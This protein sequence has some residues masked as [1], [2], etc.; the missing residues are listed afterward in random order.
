MGFLTIIFNTC[1]GKTSRENINK[2]I[3]YFRRL[4]LPNRPSVPNLSYQPSQPK[5]A[6]PNGGNT[7]GKYSDILF[8]AGKSSSAWLSAGRR[9]QKLISLWYD[10]MSQIMWLVLTNQSRVTLLRNFAVRWSL[11]QLPSGEIA[12]HKDLQSVVL[13]LFTVNSHA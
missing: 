8:L 12:L 2:N 13:N 4:D 10:Y 3:F 7:T 1:P 6:S 5:T 9:G 11:N